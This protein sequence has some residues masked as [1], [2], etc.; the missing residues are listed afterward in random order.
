MLHVCS[1]QYPSGLKSTEQRV[2]LAIIAH[3]TASCVALG[4]YRVD[5]T[6][7]AVPRGR[8]DQA[9]TV[10]GK[11]SATDLGAV[12]RDHGLTSAP[13]FTTPAAGGASSASARGTAAIRVP[14]WP[15][16]WWR[17]SIQCGARWHDRGRSVVVATARSTSLQTLLQCRLDSARGRIPVQPA[18][19]PSALSTER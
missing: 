13:L 11:W 15:S 16:R 3:W 1:M 19:V 2:L 14:P 5:G 12:P 18:C 7:A 4:P 10:E 6:V 17:W 9:R 8:G